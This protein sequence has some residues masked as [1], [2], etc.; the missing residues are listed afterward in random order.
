MD[1]RELALRFSRGDTDAFSGLIAM[2]RGGAER[3]A[4]SLLRDPQLAEDAV[5]EAFARI[6]AARDRYETGCAFGTYL[7]AVVRRVCID[8]LRRRK[9]RPVPSEKLPEPPADS[10]EAECL[11]RLES[12]R[13]LDT[14]AEL[15]EKDRRLLLGFSL[16]GR[17]ARELAEETG[18][19]PGQVRVRLHRIRRKIREGAREQDG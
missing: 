13:L 5:Q 14:V 10:A 17:S 19:T 11:R 9:H 12:R 8:E 4:N 3:L 2:H 1:D 7:S 6:Y 18:M 16:E 15:D